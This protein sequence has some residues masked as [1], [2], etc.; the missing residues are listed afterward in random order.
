MVK[1]DRAMAGILVLMRMLA[2]A[3]LA[4]PA[5]AQQKYTGPK[6][7]KPDVPYLL[8]ANKLVET[9]A[10]SATESAGKDAAV[11]SIPGAAA[12]A[13]TPMA[14]P[15][16]LL[17]S[18]KLNPESFSLYRLEVKG[19]QRTLTLP[20]NPRKDAPRPIRHSA[21]R[22]GEG[23]F[24]IEAQQYCEIGEYCLSPEGSNQVF[25]FSVY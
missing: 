8:H 3:L 19:G 5:M 12:S 25:C 20:K 16:F 14:E 9:D 21:T 15:I 17:N 2:L 24:K 4:F 7:P 22:L 13:R 11:Y 1:K 18:Q 23:L 10:G 6:P